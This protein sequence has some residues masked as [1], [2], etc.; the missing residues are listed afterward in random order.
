[1]LKFFPNTIGDFE[2]SLSQFEKDR[3]QKPTLLYQPVL[4]STNQW[5]LSVNYND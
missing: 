5:N 1:M 4:K 2:Y 3:D